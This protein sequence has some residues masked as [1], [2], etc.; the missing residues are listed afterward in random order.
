MLVDFTVRKGKKIYFIHIMCI[1][2]YKSIEQVLAMLIIDYDL[3]S[4]AISRK[5]YQT[6]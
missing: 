4:Y 1:P 6:A 5:H 3:K 2:L